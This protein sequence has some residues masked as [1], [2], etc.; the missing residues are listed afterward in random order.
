M[1]ITVVSI[2]QGPFT[3]TGLAQTVDYTFM[4]LTDDEISVFYDIG[5]G[6]VAVDPS[7]YVVSRDK[8]VDGSAKEGGSVQISAASISSGASI[9]L[10]A[11][12]RDDRDLVWSDTGSRLKNLNEEQ[13]RITLRQL[14]ASEQMA[15]AILVEPGA[16]V[17]SPQSIIESAELLSTYIPQIGLSA[18]PEKFGAVAGSSVSLLIAGANTVALRNALN[19]GFRIDGNGQVYE[20]LGELRPNVACRAG[21]MTLRQR[22]TDV[23]LEKSFLIDGVSSG[24][25]ILDGI[26]FDENNL[27]KSAGMGQAS[28]VQISNCNARVR[29][30]NVEVRNGGGITGIKIVLCPQVQIINPIVRAFTPVY[31]SQPLDDVCQGIEFSQCTGFV[32]TGALIRD[33]AASWPGRPSVFRQYSRG[34]VTGSCSGGS[35]SGS[36]IIGIEQGIDISGVNNR[37][38]AV[39]ENQILDAGTW[40]IK[41]ANFFYNITIQR[42]LI[43]RPGGAGITCSAPGTTVGAM[44][45]GVL[46]QGNTILNPG[47]SGLYPANSDAFGPRGP[48]GIKISGRDVAQP[49]FPDGVVMFGNRI[50]DDQ[51]V[52][53]GVWGIDVQQTN[54]SAPD[55]PDSAFPA[56]SNRKMVQEWDNIIE[57][58]IAGRQRGCQYSRVVPGVSGT[59]SLASG[60]WTAVPF[61]GS[62]IDDTAAM[63]DPAGAP[64]RFFAREGGVYAVSATFTHDNN[65]AGSP[66]PL[67]GLRFRRNGG[68]ETDAFGSNQIAAQTTFSPQIAISVPGITLKAGEY[69]EVEAFQNSGAPIINGLSGSS[70]TM[71]LVQRGL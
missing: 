45:S 17:P 12:P 34:I 64:T 43:V 21:N 4:T 28:A 36:T 7:F 44:P 52:K 5:A 42:N 26:V 9:Y 65:G 39:T 66:A 16:T 60:T 19:S 48:C 47:A 32:C 10:R 38:I 27:Q 13:D 2:D 50:V 55:L 63:H 14:I 49:G 6:R 53:T 69:L 8:N 46:I 41:C 61:S 24:D 35:I 11:N 29:L 54:S 25:I 1:T 22:S 62:D 59:V 20:Y 58:F 18:S 56:L 40:G 68:G 37:D 31:G 15:R 30:R 71:A 3:A 23:T 33:M 67:R 57:G 70:L 51:A